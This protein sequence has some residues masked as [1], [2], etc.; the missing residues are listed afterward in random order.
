MFEHPPKARCASLDACSE[1][2][3]RRIASIHPIHFM[4]NPFDS[5]S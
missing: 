2:E 4:I 5:F 1:R 3:K